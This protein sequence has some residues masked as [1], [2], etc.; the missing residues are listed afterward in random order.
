MISGLWFSSRKSFLRVRAV[1]AVEV[2]PTHLMIALPQNPDF[3]RGLDKIDRLGVEQQLGRTTRPAARH[4]AEGAPSVAHQF[5][6]RP[7]LGCRPGRQL[8]VLDVRKALDVPWTDSAWSL[9]PRIGCR[10][11]GLVVEIVRGKTNT[12]APIGICTDRRWCS[13]DGT[14]IEAAIDQPAERSRT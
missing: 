10:F 5:I 11:R 14:V 1:R 9:S 3:S 7:H 13:L 12:A 8:R 6:V 4:R 2:D